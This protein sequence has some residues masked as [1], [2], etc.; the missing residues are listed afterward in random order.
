MAKYR[1]YFRKTAAKELEKLPKAT[2]RKVV[3]RIE[4]LST[5]PRPA[6]CEKLSRLELYRIRQGD[7]RIV[8]SIQDSELTI[9]VIKVG[10]RKEVYKRLPT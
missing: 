6:G 9:W 3:D 5:N 1:I 2:L 7:Y 4:D 10:H 8:Y